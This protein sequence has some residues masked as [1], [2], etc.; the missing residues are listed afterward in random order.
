MNR[1]TIQPKAH[2]HSAPQADPEVVAVRSELRSF[3]PITL[4][5]MDAVALQDRQETKFV[6]D[7]ALLID[8]LPALA[9]DYSV[10][11]VAG[12][13]L[14][15]YRTLY[16]DTPNLDLYRSHQAGK[17]TRF[18]VRSREY[19]ETHTSFLEVKKRTNRKRTL[20]RRMMTNGLVTALGGVGAGF[21][22]DEFPFEAGLLTPVLWNRYQ[23]MTLVGLTRLERITLDLALDFEGA[24]DFASMGSAALPG[25]VI[26]EV[27]QPRLTRDSPFLEF[28]R[29]AHVRAT[30]FSKYCMGVTMLIPGVPSN[31][32]RRHQRMLERNALSR[33]TS[34][35]PA[36]AP[37]AWSESVAN[38]GATHVYA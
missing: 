38:T 28:L 6:L 32:F 35:V 14:S 1:V 16:F 36:F 37:F 29:G 18:K 9:A 15:R 20:K 31:R 34:H 3:R 5:E 26:A 30:S 11:N 19:V 27:K 7:L 22:D 8:L 33:T 2:A 23:R 21:V 12:E 24:G 13:R 10:L 4:A 25:V 17:P